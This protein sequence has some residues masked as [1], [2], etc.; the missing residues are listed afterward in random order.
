M[1][2]K[3]LKILKIKIDAI[4]RNID[5]LNYLNGE[6]DK[7]NK[8][9]DY[10]DEKIAL[11]KDGNVLKFEEISK[12]D[13]EEILTMVNSNVS[14]IFKDKTCNYEGIIYI[15]EGIRKSISLELTPEQT[16]AIL[17]FIE[18]MKEK[19]DNLLETIS[20]LSESKTRLPET[21]LSILTNDLDV[22]D[23]MV[24][25]FENSLYLTE[26][27]ELSEALDYAGVDTQEKSD[28]FEYVLK[29]NADIYSLKESNDFSNPSLDDEVDFSANDFKYEDVEVTNELE[30]DDGDSSLDDIKFNL[31][32]F[33]LDNLK[34]DTEADMPKKVVDYSDITPTEEVELPKINIEPSI[35]ETP[36]VSNDEPKLDD[37]ILNSE[38][39]DD[40]HELNTVELNDIIRKIDDKLKEMDTQE[41][42]DVVFSSEP[43]VETSIDEEPANFEIPSAIPEIKNEEVELPT[44]E[45][46]N[47][48]DFQNETTINDLINKYSLSDL[49][50]NNSDL[51]DVDLMLKVLSDNNLM[52]LFKNNKHVFELMLDSYN[53]TD[54]EELFSLIRE[55]LVV[56][57]KEYSKTLETLLEV[58]PIL[59]TNK[60]V[61]SSFKENIKFFK[62]KNINIINLF[63]NYRELLIMNNG[64]LVKNYNKITAY[65]FDINNDNVKYFLYNKNVLEKLDYYIEAYGYEKGFLGKEEHFDG[66]SY[67]EKNPYKLNNASRDML[68]KLRFASENN[69]KIYGNKPGI[70]AGEI[71]NPKV[72]IINLTPEY[73]N[74]YFSGDYEFVDKSELV[75]LKNEL[76]NL[77]NF[78]MT[79]DSNIMKLDANYKK[80][81]LKYQFDKN[82][83]SRV[84]TIRIYNYLKNRYNTHDALIIALTYNSVLEKSEYDSIVNIVTNLLG[85]M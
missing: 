84:K 38:V 26:I 20:N 3:L 44:I 23:N 29:Y 39:N 31:D 18:G 12:E 76:N 19:H 46:Y 49:N 74:S 43:K 78:D 66:V 67:I 75:T 21:D 7:N 47:T 42:A 13:F 34:L 64:L 4:N 27:D 10:I 48:T 9:L 17:A 40:N 32:N 5:N 14:D 6:L 57:E 68:L 2:D 22:Y 61:F 79:I 11:F 73:L 1:E 80:N 81:D 60:E 82:I 58:M 51:N 69:T 72:D 50:I 8:Y 65:G 53:S 16:N 25:K 35:D 15:I 70:L 37:A 62:E 83:I 59:F 56:K 24:S 85:G 33:D 45:T 54:L 28:M 52:D 30:K 55:N 36:E 77:D 41:N 71:T 63:D